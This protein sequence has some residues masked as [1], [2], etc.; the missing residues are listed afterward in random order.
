MSDGAALAMDQGTGT[1]AYTM[2][3]AA[4]TDPA[5]TNQT[6][7]E[8]DIGPGPGLTPDES[9]TLLRESQDTY[10]SNYPSVTEDLIQQAAQDLR[11]AQNTGEANA[12]APEQQGELTQAVKEQLLQRLKNPETREKVNNILQDD[13]FNGLNE[14]YDNLIDEIVKAS[15][16]NTELIMARASSF[17]DTMISLAAKDIKV[18]NQR[19]EAR[20]YND[21]KIQTIRFNQAAVDPTE[22]RT[23]HAVSGAGLESGTK[24]FISQNPDLMDRYQQ[25]LNNLQGDE[26]Q[27]GMLKG[28]VNYAVSEEEMSPEARQN[29]IANAVDFI[30]LSTNAIVYMA[31]HPEETETYKQVLNEKRQELNEQKK[32]DEIDKFQQTIDYLAVAPGLLSETRQALITNSGGLGDRWSQQIEKGLDLPDNQKAEFFEDLRIKVNYTAITSSLSPEAQNEL[33]SNSGLAEMWE[34]Q[35]AKALELP[36]WEGQQ[37]FVNKLKNFVEAKSSR[38]AA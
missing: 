6:A 11:P 9:A 35:M 25:Q 8:T 32:Q 10:T 15:P 33:N 19:A 24:D 22:I 26:R 21:I 31:S 37:G 3:M 7:T 23:S 1:N 34:S 29:M 2:A 20:L 28:I 27:L 13:K 17:S 38:E 14:A 12:A 36:S 4:T 5:A 30:G 18:S 16:D